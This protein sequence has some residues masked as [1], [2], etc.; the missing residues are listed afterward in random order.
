GLAQLG[1]LQ[2]YSPLGREC[3]LSVDQ[4]N[5]NYATI[6]AWAALNSF[7]VLRNR[8]LERF[9]SDELDGSSSSLNKSSGIARLILHVFG[10]MKPVRTAA[11][12]SLERASLDRKST[13]LNSSHVKISYAVF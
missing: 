3:A 5:A 4:R 13:R 7:E 12:E 11:L 2:S 6:S 9:L 10:L 1:M 8:E